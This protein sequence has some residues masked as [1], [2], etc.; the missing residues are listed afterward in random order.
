MPSLDSVLSVVIPA[1]IIIFFAFFMYQ[2][3]KHI[4][5]PAWERMKAL[6]GNKKKHVEE[7]LNAQPQQFLTYK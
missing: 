5:D 2:K 1:G 6:F 4:I 7:Q 3:T